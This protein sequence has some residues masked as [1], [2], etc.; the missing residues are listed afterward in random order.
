MYSRSLVR[1]PRSRRPNRRSF[2][3]ASLIT[4]AMVC[5]AC[6]LL[7]AAVV[8]ILF[9]LVTALALFTYN[10]QDTSWNTAGIATHVA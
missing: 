5:N 4:C 2:R 3:V 8:V 9:A 7:A 6:F 10:P 1:Q